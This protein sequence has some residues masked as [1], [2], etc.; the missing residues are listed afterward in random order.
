MLALEVIVLGIAVYGAICLIVWQ[1]QTRLIF[2]PAR[3]VRRT[4]AS[5]GIPG[6]EVRLPFRAS[7]GQD[8]HLDA[9][10]LASEES[11]KVMLYLHGNG[12]NIGVNLPHA[13]LLRS[14]GISV[15][16]FDYRGYGRSSGAFPTEPQIYEDA[17]VAWNYLVTDRKVRP[18]QIV[19]YGH[20]LG[21]AIAIELASRHP[22]AAGLIVE[23]SFT[24]VLE[25]ARYTVAFRLFPVA[26]LLRHRFESIAKVGVLRMPILFLHGTADWTVPSHMTSTLFATASEPKT[27]MMIEGGGHLNNSTIGGQRY[28][29]AIREFI[30]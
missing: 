6:D 11:P 14:L 1:W 30:L 15:F 4:P 24:S 3:K 28:L 27:L 8:E 25:M 12:D 19:I 10:W 20:S 18:E 29:D 7:N 9:F 5:L 16:L 13:V 26:R 22:E 23:S 17:E 21:G 2:M